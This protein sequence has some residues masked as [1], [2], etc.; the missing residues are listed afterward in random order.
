MA[1][2]WDGHLKL[3]R[4]KSHATTRRYRNNDNR[5]ID[6]SKTL[7]PCACRGRAMGTPT[8]MTHVWSSVTVKRAL[9][10]R[11]PVLKPF[12]DNP[13]DATIRSQKHHRPGATPQPAGRRRPSRYRC[14]TPH[15]EPCT[16]D[17]V[18]PNPNDGAE[19]SHSSRVCRSLAR[20]HNFLHRIPKTSSLRANDVAK[21]AVKSNS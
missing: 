1:H 11:G 9:V 16:V 20:V 12:L 6:L 4:P 7:A 18:S 13:L 5:T 14:R 19:C 15:T 21:R 2:F 17:Q 3:P 8:I 10:K